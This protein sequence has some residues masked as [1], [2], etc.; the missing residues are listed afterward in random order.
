[1][2]A[3]GGA[4]GCVAG[5]ANIPSSPALTA[6]LD[7]LFR[8]IARRHA[9]AQQNGPIFLHVHE[10]TSQRFPRALR[11]TTLLRLKQPQERNLLLIASESRTEG[12]RRQ[13]GEGIHHAGRTI[14]CG[15]GFLPSPLP[16]VAP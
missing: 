7:K 3:C 5:A 4:D 11:R 1:M 10:N 13:E 12:G 8:G 2:V 16:V 6:R 15:A 9:T 14:R